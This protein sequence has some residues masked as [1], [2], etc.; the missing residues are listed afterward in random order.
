MDCLPQDQGTI[1]L[2]DLGRTKCEFKGK[3]KAEVWEFDVPTV[4]S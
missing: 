4:V 2:C 3:N 1:F